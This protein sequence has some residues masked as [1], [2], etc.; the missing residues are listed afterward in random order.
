MIRTE[1]AKHAIVYG[2]AGVVGGG[3]SQVE[4]DEMDGGVWKVDRMQGATMSSWR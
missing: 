3:G 1:M 2:C 4:E